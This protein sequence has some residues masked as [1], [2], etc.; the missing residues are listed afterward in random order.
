MTA[1]RNRRLYRCESLEIHLQVNLSISSLVAL[2]RGI[3]RMCHR[4]GLARAQ[5]AADCM[6]SL[7]YIVRAEKALKI[8]LSG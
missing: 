8:N 1:D 2:R 3:L 5:H 4:E 6:K 7:R